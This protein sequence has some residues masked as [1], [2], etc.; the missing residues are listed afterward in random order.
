MPRGFI[1]WRLPNDRNA[2]RHD[3][4]TQFLAAMPA[5]PISSESHEFDS[6]SMVLHSTT[7]ADL[8]KPTEIM[9]VHDETIFFLQTAAEIEHSLLV[10]YLYA[11]FSLG[12]VDRREDLS[13]MQK[14][15][16][17]TWQS[18]IMTIAKQEMAHLIT[19]QNLLRLIGGPL[20]FEREDFPFRSQYYPFP[21]R[22]EPLTKESL[23]KY[24]AAEMP[25]KPDDPDGFVADALRRAQVVTGAPVN[26]IGALYAKL[27]ELF[28]DDQTLKDEVF[29]PQTAHTFQ[30][31]QE[32]WP[33]GTGMIIRTFGGTP[34]QARADA[35]RALHD[36]AAEGEGAEAPG[37]GA[38][39][40]HF[41]LF[42]EIY[43]TFP[44]TTGHF[45]YAWK[46]AIAVP[47][48]PSTAPMALTDPQ[49]TDPHSELGRISH[50]VS[51]DWAR[52][53]NLRYRMLLT[54]WQQSLHTSRE[55]ATAADRTHLINWA[56]V[57]MFRM[58]RFSNNVLAVMPRKKPN[59]FDDGR[60]SIAA[61]PFEL[62]YSLLMPDQDSDRWR[63]VLDLVDASKT[64]CGK[65]CLTKMSDAAK[66]VLQKIRGDDAKIREYA[67]KHLASSGAGGVPGGGPAFLRQKT[68]V[69]TDPK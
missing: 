6:D 27:I 17:I 32:E 20:N 5:E 45:P 23:A 34:R 11:S 44:E 56:F 1:E 61:A 22:L 46:P 41:S 8:P 19:V 37:P 18:T 30:A 57:E 3:R 55:A 60:P 69:R 53:F 63:S 50:P 59:T 21:F 35:L 39:P 47:C 62:P 13:A 51:V 12:F 10:Q 48:H 65:L 67:T 2:S 15:Q 38:S 26:R 9:S 64:I 33:G 42:L 40:S 66:A 28:T 31:T 14:D 43:Q 58:P 7:T 16:A 29:S 52:L 24:I 4:V 36:I 25:E 68:R 54:F 49:L